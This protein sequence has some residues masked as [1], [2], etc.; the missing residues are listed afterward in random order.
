M[1]V[2]FVVGAGDYTGAAKM[3]HEYAK[4][5]R[6]S[7][8]D[9]LFIVGDPPKAGFDCLSSFL[10]RDKFTFIEQHGFTK[11][12]SNT[13]IN[14]LRFAI[15]TFNP[16]FVLSTVQI[17]LK[18]VGPVCRKLKIPYV[19]FDQTVHTFFGSCIAKLLKNIFFGFEMRQAAG[20]IAVG[21]AVR[22]QAIKS[23]FCRPGNICVIPNGTSVSANPKKTV[24]KFFTDK[25]CIYGLNVGRIDPQKGQHLLIQALNVISKSNK[26]I[27]IDLAGDSTPNHKES[28]NY[29]T[30]CI[31]DANTYR[32]NSQVRFLGWQHNIKT[33]FRNYDFYVHSAL[34]E[35]PALPLALLEAMSF[36]LPIIMNDCAGKPPFFKQGIHGWIVKSGDVNS[37]VYALVQMNNLSK[38]KRM[39]MGI[40]CRRL[41]EKHYNIENTGKL[42]V[43]ACEGFLQK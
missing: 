17:D 31:N 5:G 29:K 8:W 6:N 10:R 35:G 7:G 1:K 41:V 19:V 38:A 21:E 11:L 40:Q 13:L 18:I 42:F 4:I 27:F 9:I 28:E 36:G 20:V 23:F 33:I 22:T 32:L 16:D 24:R 37:L 34:W 14:K 2:V 15:K 30:R 43:S 12:R 3:A 25:Y 39:Q 26:N